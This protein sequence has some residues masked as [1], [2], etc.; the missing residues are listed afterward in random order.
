M[1]YSITQSFG[2]EHDSRQDEGITKSFT[3][4]KDALNYFKEVKS[5]SQQGGTIITDLWLKDEVIDTHYSEFDYSKLYGKLVIGY[6]HEGKGMGY[7]H[8]FLEAFWL[9][10]Y[11]CDLSENPDNRF[12]IWHTITNLSIDDLNNLSYED[13]I[14]KVKNEVN[15]RWNNSIDLSDLGINFSH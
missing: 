13:A 14:N 6:Q 5:N 2:T 9:D 8:K 1:K 10:K 15:L 4:K 12:R 7:C 3:N 11:K